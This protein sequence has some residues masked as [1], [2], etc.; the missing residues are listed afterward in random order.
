MFM[1]LLLVF[2][3]CINKIII[4]AIEIDDL[5][6]KIIDIEEEFDKI[7]K[8]KELNENQYNLC[9][10]ITEYTTFECFEEEAKCKVI[11]KLGCGNF[12][13]VWKVEVK[14]KDIGE[15][16]Y[17]NDYYERKLLQR[18]N[19]LRQHLSK[20][21]DEKLYVAVKILKSKNVDLASTIVEAI[22]WAEVPEHHNVIDLIHTEILSCN[23]LFYTELVEG[24]DVDNTDPNFS[25]KS[26]LVA[27]Q[28][29]LKA[30]IGLIQGLIHIHNYNLHHFDIKPANLMV[31]KNFDVKI[32]DFGLAQANLSAIPVQITSSGS[33]KLGGTPKKLIRGGTPIYMSPE[34]YREFGSG[35]PACVADHLHDTSGKQHMCCNCHDNFA[36]ALTILD[37][38][39]QFSSN[40]TLTYF[41]DDD[42]SDKVPIGKYMFDVSNEE[43][44]KKKSFP[45]MPKTIEIEL[46]KI[47]NEN[48][49]DRP[50][51]LRDLEAAIIKESKKVGIDFA[52]YFSESS[53]KIGHYVLQGSSMLKLATATVDHKT[54]ENLLKESARIFET[55]VKLVN[56]EAKKSDDVD[57]KAVKI[58]CLEKLGITLFLLA[59]EKVDEKEKFDAIQKSVYNFIEAANDNLDENLYMMSVQ[60][61]SLHVSDY[62]AKA[63]ESYTESSFYNKELEKKFVEKV[64]K[65][66]KSMIDSLNSYGS[67]V[68]SE[69]D[70]NSCSKFIKVY[71]ASLKESLT[72]SDKDNSSIVVGNK[73][74]LLNDDLY[75]PHF[76]VNDI[77]TVSNIDK[78][79]N[80]LK[81]VSPKLK[82]AW[83]SSSHVKV[84]DIIHTASGDDDIDWSPLI[85]LLAIIITLVC[86]CCCACY[87]CFRPRQRKLHIE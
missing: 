31:N 50:C 79:N 51:D 23:L 86:V 1:L 19:V 82:A 80:L 5:N 64:S 25:K 46:K 71:I 9:D 35:A 11:K 53:S 40:H 70:E 34:I 41:Y 43:K 74:I 52:P 26:T 17:L 13:C 27:T 33:F 42:G 37:L 73:V 83:V 10:T 68:E 39:R 14:F 24:D 18:E 87:C 57:L 32:C 20:G 44:L 77:A 62:Y 48:F 60:H 2:L 16:I 59:S 12:G 69:N 81:I 29:L 47:L 22:N 30:T 54:R 72:E 21:S 38:W 28:E 15:Q 8:I 45:A 75:K 65:I 78:K 84:V 3:L 7:D 55:V 66:G 56:S 76:K 61:V 6:A 36:A 49:I 63:L 4:N 67:C 58:H 85:G